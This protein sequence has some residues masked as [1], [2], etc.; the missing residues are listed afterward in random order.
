M[1]DTPVTSVVEEPRKTNTWLIVAI[2]AIVLCCCCVLV[3]ALGW[4][5]GDCLTNPN[6]PALCPLASTLISTL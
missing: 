4:V 3:V 5:Y 1:E 2:I 6:D